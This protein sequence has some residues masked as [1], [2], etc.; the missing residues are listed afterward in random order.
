[1][2]INLIWLALAALFFTH[3]PSST[4]ADTTP[5][6][7]FSILPI[8]GITVSNLTQIAVAFNE[9]VTGVTPGALQINGFDADSVSGTN[10]T[11]FIFTF[12]QPPPGQV[13]L[14][15]DIDQSI[16]ELSA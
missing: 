7:V 6:A 8:P 14:Y 1:M 4:A 3:L 5:P 13:L 15:F 10:P 16:T 2:R 12:T 11:N 9:P